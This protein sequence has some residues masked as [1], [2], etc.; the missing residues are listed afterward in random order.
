MTDVRVVASKDPSAGLALRPTALSDFPIFTGPFSHL[1]AERDRLAG[2]RWRS[3]E[4][5]PM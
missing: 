3:F 2:L 1:A 5:V 4:A